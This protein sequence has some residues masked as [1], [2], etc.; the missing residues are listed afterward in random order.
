MVR[1][2]V[3]RTALPLPWFRH[4]VALLWGPTI[5]WQKSRSVASGAPSPRGDTR[6]LRPLV[7]PPLADTSILVESLW[8]YIGSVW[9]PKGA[10]VDEEAAEVRRVFERFE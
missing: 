4:A 1:R 8:S 2:G 10:S 5:D 6:P 7:G 3:A 9:P